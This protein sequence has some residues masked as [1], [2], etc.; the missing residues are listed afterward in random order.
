MPLNDPPPYLQICEF[1]T[2][3]SRGAERVAGT[4]PR[5][6]CRVAFQ[7]TEIRI[8]NKTRYYFKLYHALNL[9]TLLIADAIYG[10]GAGLGYLPIPT[11]GRSGQTVIERP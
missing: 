8:R 1:R 7:R 9:W 5:Q 11:C 2:R 4:P 6:D 3:V 10:H